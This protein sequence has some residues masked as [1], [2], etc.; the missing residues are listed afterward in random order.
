MVFG[1]WT[2]AVDGGFSSLT[3]PS[4]GA[5]VFG[6]YVSVRYLPTKERSF[7]FEAAYR[8]VWHE[9]TPDLDMGVFTDITVSVAY[10]V[11]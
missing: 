4:I 5:G 9:T 1:A 7:G 11:M 2:F 8:A 10:R 3:D 6:T